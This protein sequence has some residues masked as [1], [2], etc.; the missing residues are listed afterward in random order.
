MYS[1]ITSSLFALF[2]TAG[3]AYPQSSEI[4]P[5]EAEPLTIPMYTVANCMPGD[6]FRPYIIQ[7]FGHEPLLLGYGI[8][9]IIQ[10]DGSAIAADGAMFLT[11]NLDTG[12][13]IVSITFPDDMICNLISG[14]D[15]QPM[16]YGP[17]GTDL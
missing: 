4:W 9:S 1:K 3:C 11:A 17:P 14:L 5:D 13:W 15:L 12:T 7:N 6:E 16:S 10:D 8:I 2:V